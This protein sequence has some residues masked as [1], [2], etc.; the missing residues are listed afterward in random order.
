MVKRTDGG[1]PEWIKPAH[2]SDFFVDF[3]QAI[4]LFERR[5]LAQQQAAIAASLGVDV[6]PAAEEPGILESWG[7]GPVPETSE[8]AP[9]DEEDQQLQYQDYA[10]LYQSPAGGWLKGVWRW[11][12]LPDFP[13]Q[14]PPSLSQQVQQLRAI[15]QAAAAAAAESADGPGAPLPGDNLGD[16]LP[17][18]A[19]GDASLGAAQAMDLDQVWA[20]LARCQEVEGTLQRYDAAA[21]AARSAQQEKDQL[22]SRHKSAADEAAHLHAELTAVGCGGYE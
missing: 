3:G 15:L 19:D 10:Q 5:R 2:N 11:E 21:L 7:P 4:R 16:D 20:L 13:P 18:V 22:W 14:Q 8:A 17:V 9:S 1:A 6:D 12:Q